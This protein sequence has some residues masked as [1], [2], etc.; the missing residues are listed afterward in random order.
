MLPMALGLGEGGEQNAPP[1][2]ALNSV[3][4]RNRLHVVFRARG[5]QYPADRHDSLNPVPASPLLEKPMSRTSSCSRSPDANCA[6]AAGRR[7]FFG[8]FPSP[9]PAFGLVSRAAQKLAPARFNAKPGRCRRSPSWLP[10]APKITRTNVTPGC[11]F[12]LGANLRPRVPAYSQEP[13]K[14]QIRS[15]AAGAG[16]A[17]AVQLTP[18]ISSS[19]SR[20][21]RAASERRPGRTRSSPR[22]PRSA[23]ANPL[24]YRRLLR[25]KK[26]VQSAHFHLE[27]QCRRRSR[28]R[29]Q[30]STSSSP[31][32]ASNA[33]PRR[34]TASSPRA[35]TESVRSSMS[36]LRA[37]VALGA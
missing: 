37:Y 30:A 10:P 2:L 22:S 21:A 23:P 13:K 17:L 9:S 31:K 18:P 8:L 24:P 6:A 15:R 28:P 25:R 34:S 20:Q 16:D 27:R 33:S 36:V 11:F 7:P 3:H 1:L 29:R 14:S 26:E 35:E 19:Y 5:V 32:R 12:L 4:L